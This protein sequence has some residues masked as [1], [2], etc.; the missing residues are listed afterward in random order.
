MMVSALWY[1][2]FGTP[3]AVLRMERHALSPLLP[4]KLR[5]RMLAAP[6]NPSDLIPMTGAYRHRVVPPLVAGYEGV[7]R[8][9]A[10]PDFPDWVGRR[11]LPLRA[12]GTWQTVLDCTPDWLVPVPDEID[13][14]T[15][16]RAYINPLAALLMLQRFPVAGRRI[17]LSAARSG[18][19][20]LLAATAAQR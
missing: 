5:V 8:V 3:E 7:G 19:A 17:V 12:S 14:V 6:I 10:A 1:R 18:C 2:A 11:V 20:R 16:A 9:I 13:D 4:G 15:A